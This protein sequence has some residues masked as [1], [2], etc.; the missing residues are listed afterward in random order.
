MAA[1]FPGVTNTVYYHLKRGSVLGEGE[2]FHCAEDLYNSVHSPPDPRYLYT[3]MEKKL[4][5]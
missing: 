2:M 3:V 5:T 4:F 1:W